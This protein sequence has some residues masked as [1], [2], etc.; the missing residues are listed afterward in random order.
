MSC[1][2]YDTWPQRSGCSKAQTSPPAARSRQSLLTVQDM[3][4]NSGADRLL[5]TVQRKCAACQQEEEV[6]AQRAVASGEPVP[7]PETA[8]ELA[9]SAP[10]STEPDS[11]PTEA[12]FLPASLTLGG[13]AAL[14]ASLT[15][16]TP[17]SGRLEAEVLWAFVTGSFIPFA[18]GA[19]GL[20][21]AGLWISYLGR[22]S[23]AMPRPSQSFTSLTSTVVG[24]FNRHPQH[25][26]Q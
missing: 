3:L 16:C 18:T 26:H 8:P 6:F 21:T 25:S 22:G 24:G 19:F 15:P 4:G 13:I 10:E 11:G 7:G 12:A 23:S 2:A 17:A 9:G 1:A 20:E 14:L 5:H